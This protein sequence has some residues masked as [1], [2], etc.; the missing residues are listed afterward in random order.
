MEQ[1]GIVLLQ[2]I[3]ATPSDAYPELLGHHVLSCRWGLSTVVEGLLIEVGKA[4]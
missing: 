3:F 2:S 4:E 1:I